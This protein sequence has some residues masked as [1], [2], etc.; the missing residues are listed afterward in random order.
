M[1][2][3]PYL[4]LVFAKISFTFGLTLS[5]CAPIY[6]HAADVSEKPAHKL[7]AVESSPT[8]AD[9]S[10]AQKKALLPLENLWPTLEINRKRKWLAVAQNFVNMNE[11][12]QALAQE[13]MREWAALSPLQRTQA[14]LNFAQTKQLSGD[15]K[16]AK[17]EAYQA[18][19]E[20]E[21]QKLPSSR[22]T[23]PKGA[24]PTAKPV[25]QD[26]LTSTPVKKDGQGTS[27]RIDTGQLN[28]FTLLPA[29]LQASNRPYAVQ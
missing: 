13:R 21:K 11:A 19:S 15:E 28:P 29:N 16:L 12:S 9:L 17:W 7:T 6:S 1:R 23:P 18:L 27:P 3:F 20:D 26:K 8:W 5:L 2:A 24:A 4:N 14:R 22:Q 25:S 10:L